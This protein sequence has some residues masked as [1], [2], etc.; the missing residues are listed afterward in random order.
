MDSQAGKAVHICN[1]STWNVDPERADV[2]GYIQ[3][4]SESEPNL[5]YTRP[6]LKIKKLVPGGMLG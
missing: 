3:L 4:R 5:G 1:A 6:Y 2:K